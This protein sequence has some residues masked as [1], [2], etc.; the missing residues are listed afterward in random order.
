MFGE[1][2]L[3]MQRLSAVAQAQ[4]R[5]LH[6]NRPGK[7]ARP[8]GVELCVP[9]SCLTC[10]T[11]CMCDRWPPSQRVTA[12]LML[13]PSRVGRSLAV[14]PLQQQVLGGPSG[15]VHQEG[16]EESGWEGTPGWPLLGPLHLAL[17][18]VEL[19]CDCSG[20]VASFLLQGPEMPPPP[21]VTGV[22]A[23]IAPWCQEL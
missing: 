16:G 5:R 10:A 15:N 19:R 20:G 22:P 3:N 1:S 8:R 9:A 21:C 13:L 14:L 17:N 6:I 23:Q 12:A 4:I 7:L 2:A 18:F 11:A